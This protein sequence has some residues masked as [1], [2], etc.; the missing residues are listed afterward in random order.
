MTIAELLSHR[1]LVVLVV[2]AV[3]SLIAFAG[4][5]FDKWAARRS[6]RRVPE[7]T[8][9]LWSL[10]GGWPGALVAQRVFRHKTRKASFQIVFWVSVALNCAAVAW[11]LSPAGG[12]SSEKQTETGAPDSDLPVIRPRGR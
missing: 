6:S 3:A 8:L 11:W 7:N 12:R 1:W 2:S 4:Y 9:H 5:G 10:L